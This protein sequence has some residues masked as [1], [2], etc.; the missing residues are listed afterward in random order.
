[1]YANKYFSE[2]NKVLN[3]IQST[4]LE[5]IKSAAN[6]IVEASLNGSNIYAFGCNHAGLLA[7]ELFYRSGG[8]AIINPILAP[9]LALMYF[10]LH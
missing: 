4:Q 10:L 2:L 3:K 1:M 9:G 7:Q 8:L 5:N 6:M